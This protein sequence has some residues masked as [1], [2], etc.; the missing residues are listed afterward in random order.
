MFPQATRKPYP[1][2]LTN[3]QWEWLA[4]FI[5][6]PSPD[7]TVPTISR[8]EIVNGMWSILRTGAS[9]RPMPHDVPNGKTVHSSFRLWST[10]GIWKQAMD[11]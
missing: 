8:R 1:S 6:E 2:D 5:P 10:Q 4:P 7:A 11:T 3:A 9:W